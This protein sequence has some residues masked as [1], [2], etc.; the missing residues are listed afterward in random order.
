MYDQMITV[1]PYDEQYKDEIAELILNIQQKEFFV[2][3]T[4][5]DQPDL[6]AIKDV[7]CRDAG[8]FWVALEDEQLA[9][10]IALID[11]GNGRGALRKMFV[12]KE[13]RG[14]EK[15]TGQL[16][17]NT[18]LQWCRE[19]GIKEIYLGTVEQLHAAKRFYE[20]NGFVKVAKGDLPKDF[21]LMQVDTEF[22][23]LTVG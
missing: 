13:M 6:L 11:F 10:T 12:R 2:P 1:K 17:L 5:Q 22:Y 7:Y 3:I 18:L 20:R 23:Q 15:G 19:K 9:G 14:K 21:P 8:N 4:L 16:L